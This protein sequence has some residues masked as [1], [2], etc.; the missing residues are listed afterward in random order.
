[1]THRAAIL[2]CLVLLISAALV[3]APAFAQKSCDSLTTLTLANTTITSATSVAAG[4]FKPPAGPGQPAPTDPLPAF[5]RVAAVARPTSDSEIKFEV[6]M[7][8]TSWN[9][10]YE[11]VGNGGFAGTI[12]LSSM[13]EPLLR[14]YSTAG[15]DDGHSSGVDPGWM[16]G[17]PEKVADFGYRAVHETSLAA[18]KIVE[19]FY[20]RKLARSYFVG[21]SDGG[22]EALMEA[23]RYPD[24]FVGIVAGDPANNWTRLQAGGVW[25][26]RALKDE[27]GSGVPPAKLPALQ[28]AALAACDAIDG[29]KDGIIANPRPCHF[30]PGVIQCKDDDGSNCL[31]A[32]Q[33]AAV[34]KI[35]SGPKNPR[36]GEAIFPGFSPGAEA[37]PQNWRLWIT[38][39]A[40]GAPIIGELIGN[41]FFAY[42]A[43]QDPKWDY[44]TFD[45]DK[46]MKTADDK[47]GPVINS[48]DPDLSKFRARSGKLIQYHGW[49]DAA[50][51]TLSSVNYFESVQSV[52]G[53]T[54]RQRDLDATGDFYR[55]FMVPGMSHCAG[56][57]G[58]I[59]FGNGPTALHDPE[60]DVVAA[61]DRWV[62]KGT[63]P[64]HIIATGF[65]GD[66]A[67]GVVMTRPLCPY[68]E[69]AV[70][71]GTGDTDSAA[72]FTCQTRHKR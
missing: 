69:E 36:T 21:C 54:S 24:D 33:V 14:G 30:D 8:A 10:K 4:A 64:D 72:N 56:G 34:R 5:C 12:P 6:W 11:Q 35:Y 29:V 53:K 48:V 32:P 3:P 25:N 70:Y 71:N 19:E 16:I 63:A 18:K 62:E 60:H 15:T 40:P 9:G 57:I 27:P 42:M 49:G 44:R 23:Q 41:T 47:I 65:D 39:N 66:P 31:T 59:S 28:N 46:D 22:R 45:F 37:L 13:S 2:F 55:L 51:P 58:A 20:G 17:H 7:P 50:I 38:G 68:P 43:F 52:M 26:E 61:L 67:K 1:M